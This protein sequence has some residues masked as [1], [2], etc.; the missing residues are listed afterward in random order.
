[1]D[2]TT[3]IDA[4]Q[5]PESTSNAGMNRPMITVV[6]VVALAGVVVGGYYGYQLITKKKA[7]P[8]NEY[9]GVSNS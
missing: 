5:Q 7:Q 8:S 3:T 6:I 4:T 1:M 2:T 9:T